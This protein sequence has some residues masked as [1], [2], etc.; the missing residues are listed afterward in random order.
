MARVARDGTQTA[1]V[2]PTLLM[3]LLLLRSGGTARCSVSRALPGSLAQPVRD[4]PFPMFILRPLSRAQAGPPSRRSAGAGDLGIRTA[5]HAEVPGCSRCWDSSNDLVNELD[6]VLAAGPEAC[7]TTVKLE[8]RW[9]HPGA[10]GLEQDPRGN[11]TRSLRRL[12]Q[13]RGSPAGFLCSF[14][15]RWSTACLC[16][17]GEFL[18]QVKV[19]SG[20]RRPAEASSSPAGG[21]AACG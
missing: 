7:R 10:Q 14:R 19:G 9:R 18:L 20:V 15:H 2:W 11:S 16:F 17:L 8:P 4:C 6:L 3:P 5:G 12:P 21:L 1:L 13:F